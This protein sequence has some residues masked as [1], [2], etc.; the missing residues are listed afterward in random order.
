M[1][2]V[3]VSKAAGRPSI[4]ICALVFNIESNRQQSVDIIRLLLIIASMTCFRIEFYTYA[5]LTV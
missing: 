1:V 3:M 5:Q 2:F 4:I